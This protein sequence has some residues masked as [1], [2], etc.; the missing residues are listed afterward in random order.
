MQL[1]P[2]GARLSTK[3]TIAYTLFLLLVAGVLAISLYVQLRNA[4]RA[5]IRERLHNIVSLA[6]PQ[7]DGDFHTLISAPG[8][9]QTSYYRI[10]AERMRQVQ[11]TSS[12][13]KNM[14]T[15]RQQSDGSIVFV[16]DAN[17]G[18]DASVAV[19]QKYVQ[20]TPILQSGLS[21]IKEPVVEHELVRL[22]TDET[23]L[24][25]YGPI[26]DQLGRLD[27]VLVIELDASEVIASEARARN[28][29]IA[30]FVI[31][32][33]LVLVLG[34]GLVRYYTAPIEDLVLGAE[35]ITQGKLD[36]KVHV[37]STDELG[38]LATAFN[39]MGESLQ[40]RI[41]AEQQA[42]HELRLSH[43]QL[44]EYSLNLE[45]KVVQRTAE[46]SY[47]TTEAQEARLAAEEANRAKSQF[48][49]NMSHEL[50]TPLN[51]IIGY[52]EMLQ[53]D[54]IDLEYT[55]II[56]DLQKIH[57]AGKHLLALIN[58][59]LDL[60]KIEAGRMDLY[61]E[62]ISLD[63]MLHNII[64]T[65]QPTIEKNTNTFVVH[66]DT[67]TPTIHA[68]YT[69]VRQ[70]L[71]N[72]LSNAA[73]FTH[74]GTVQLEVCD[75]DDQYIMFRVV[76]TGIGM[77]PEQMQH[78][79]QAFTQADASTTRKY[80]GTGL[81][82]AIS[83]RFC[84]MMGGDINVTS[85]PRQGTTFTVI[86]PLDVQAAKLRKEQQQQEQP[87]QAQ[88][89]TNADRSTVYATIDTSLVSGTV[90]VIDDDPVVCDLVA[91]SL[92]RDGLHIETTRSGPEGLRRAK[93]LHPDVI[94]LDVMMPDMDGWAV[95][96]ALKSDPAIA[97]IPVIMLTIVD[98]R[99]VGF[100]L[101][102]ADYLIKPVDAN[103]LIDVVRS[104]QRCVP[105]DDQLPPDGHI[106]LVEDD[107][108][109]RDIVHRTL[110][111]EGWNV[112]NVENG[113]IA[114]EHI[115]K[116]QP[117]V[118]LLDLMMPEVDGFHVIRALRANP[119]WQA[120]PVIVMTAM[121]LTWQDRQFLA[122]SVAQVLQ[123]AEYNR[124]QLLEEVAHLVETYLLERVA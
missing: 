123:K 110:E 70:V 22:S 19:G 32:L 16:V 37:R 60:S 101:G 45:H 69:K 48:L 3:L 92:V 50:R 95:L 107:D 58:D 115:A 94:T 41:T 35:H 106:L 90:L 74:N 105:S 29:A 25:G 75:V 17:Q 42:Q 104:K 103:R 53:E 18:T 7:I 26:Y 111:Q 39:T 4:Q 36:Y 119:V 9:M 34:F 99:E 98:E 67:S 117:D 66:R 46:L 77:S 61:L 62:N 21:T 43:Q 91:R 14:Y 73:K 71:F 89:E 33:P 122:G 13:I 47:A 40:A 81:G 120:I 28:S 96:T 1:K 20:L 56:P 118:I 27:G 49:A 64:A 24:Y 116:N 10:I 108:M 44:E 109:T 72:L 113:R 79:F 52:S 23:V 51:A 83:Q 54:A 85:I 57:I 63:E 102:A 100:A 121:E 65:I 6:T 87:A 84:H 31:T 59:I 76:D 15:L 80:G 2:H 30:T 93:E 124:Q 8:D 5:A 55:D 114:L 112:V 11:A 82:L 12:A 86:L 78:L 38:V 68:D 88:D 97:N